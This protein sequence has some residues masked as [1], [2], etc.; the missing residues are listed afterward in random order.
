MS[1]PAVTDIWRIPGKLVLTPTDLTAVYPYGGTELGVISKIAFEPRPEYDQVVAQEWGGAVCKVLTVGEKPVI[2]GT[3]RSWDAAMMAQLFRQGGSGTRSGSATAGNRYV[4]GNPQSGS[5][6]PGTLV[7]GVLLMFAPLASNAMPCL[8][9]YNAKPR[10][11]IA[12]RMELAL[13]RELA[14]PFAFDLTPD[15]NGKAYLWALKDDPELTLT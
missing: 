10:I 14:V 8:I 3:L 9:G 7:G 4:S 12:A 11:D 2:Y 5:P 15:A 1:A 13:N 6:R